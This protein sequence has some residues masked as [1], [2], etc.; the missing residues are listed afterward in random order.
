MAM[1][2]EKVV[3]FGRTMDEYLHMFALD[4]GDLGKRIIACADGPDSF[5]AEMLRVAEEVRIFPLLTLLLKTSPHLVP[6][7]EAL[8]RRGFAV[9]V[10]SVDYE[11]Q[12][13]GNQ[14][15]CVSRKRG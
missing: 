5:N 11:F 14:M 7:C 9:V 8:E 13:G 4:E 15:L 6:L 2:L 12:R 10:R 3:P 1:Q